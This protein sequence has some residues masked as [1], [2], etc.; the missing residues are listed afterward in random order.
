MTILHRL[1]T[2]SQTNDFPFRG[3]VTLTSSHCCDD[4]NHKLKI[5]RIHY[6]TTNNDMK[7]RAKTFKMFFFPFM[8]QEEFLK[9]R[10]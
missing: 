2:A 5:C 10:S 9:G 6:N 4:Y 7:S 8:I 1:L 3:N